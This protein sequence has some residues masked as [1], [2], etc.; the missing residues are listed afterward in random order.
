[1]KREKRIEGFQESL[2]DVAEREQARAEVVRLKEY[3]EKI[4]NGIPSYVMVLDKD[5]NLKFVNQAYLETGK[6]RNKVIVGETFKDLYPD[7]LLKE[8]GLLEAF[9]KAIET[10]ETSKL[11]AV[12]NA[13][14]DPP[15]KL[16]N[17]TISGILS[18]EGG[19]DIILVIENDTE[20][21]R[22]AEEIRQAKNFMEAIFETTPDSVAATDK[23]GLITF[24]NRVIL[25]D[26]GYEKEE[27]EGKHVSMFYDTGIERARDIMAILSVDQELRDYRMEILTRKGMEIP[28]SLSGALIRDK[29]GKVTGTLG[30]LRDITDLVQAEE[31]I[32]KKNRK[33]EKLTITDD[34]TG[35]FNR[36]YFYRKLDKEMVRAKR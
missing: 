25:E 31:E 14:F 36:R 12:G 26:L 6:Y 17:F 15:E 23:K 33:L 30:F 20:R 9:N 29:D 4:L 32:R 1:V 18:G 10:G 5:L 24:A 19:E 8:V 7:D 2:R 21:A 34:L 27:L 22:L 16:L 11:Y 28:V 3:G 35:L 13:S